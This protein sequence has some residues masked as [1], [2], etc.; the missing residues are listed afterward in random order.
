MIIDVSD[1]VI[2]DIVLIE[3]GDYVPADIRILE[4]VNLKVDESALT[5]EAVPVDKKVITLDS[6]EIA[7]G[8]RI[9]SAYMSTVVTYGRGVGIVVNT[10]MNTEIGKIAKMIQVSKN[11]QTPLQKSIAQLGKILAVIAIIITV[12]IFAINITQHYLMDQSP[13]TWLVWKESC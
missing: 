4:S 3:A 12:L 13:I 9:N 11:D 8:D 7:L 2:G 10:G 5:G 6:E 1:I